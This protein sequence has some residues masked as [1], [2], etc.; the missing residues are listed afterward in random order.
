MI[1]VVR[2]PALREGDTVALVAPAGAL[3]ADEDLGRAI[4]HIESLGLRAR[5]GRHALDRHGY[6]AGDD[7]ARLDDI[8]VALRDPDVRAVVALRGGYGTTRLLDGVDYAAFAADPKVVLG[9]SDLTALLNALHARTGIVTF[10]GPVAAADRFTPTVVGW[11]RRALFSTAPIGTLEAPCATTLGGGRGRG[12][13]IGGNLS[14]IAALLAT[15]Y[16]LD[17]DGA[18]AFLEE[19]DEAP[20]RIDRMLTQLRAS[21][22]LHGVRGIVVG[23]CRNCDA[24]ADAPAASRLEHVLRDR[25]GDLGVPLLSG[26]PIGHIE[27]QWTLPIGIEADLDA[28]ARTLDVGA[29][30]A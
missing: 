25:L 15:P 8:N 21:G 13:L 2:P 10:H 26:A 3:H 14:L 16:A 30:V 12:R 27:E 20:Y 1:D 22:T 23:D 7:Q 4:G 24:P 17:F 18:I 5:A 11:L 9:Y 29:A 28:D 6:L 19:V